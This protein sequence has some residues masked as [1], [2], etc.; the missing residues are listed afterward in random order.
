MRKIVILLYLSVSFYCSSQNKEILYNFT[1]LPQSLLTNP[2]A[3]VKYKWFLGVPLLSGISAN[4]GSKGINAYDL[5]A[6]N[7]V[8]FN[9]KIKEVI[10]KTNRNDYV[11]ANQQ[12]ELFS[13]GFRIGEPEDRSY[14]S[15]G[16]YQEFDSFIYI[17]TDIAILSV[18][19]NKDYVGKSFNLG[20]LSVKAELLS[21]LH[22]G[23]NKP[24][25]KKMTFGVRGKIYSSIF[26]ATST[27][28]SGYFHTV[29]GKNLIYDQSIRSNLTLNTSGAAKYLD[30]NYDGDFGSD[31]VEDVKQKALLGGNLGLGFDV[32]LTYYP[33]KNIQITASLVD[34]GYIKHT[35]E[36]KSYTLK[37]NYDFKGVITDFNSNGSIN[38]AYQDFKDAIP[39][40]TLYTAYATQ[41]PL[42]F[43]SSYQYSFEE[44]RQT[45]CNCDTDEDSWYRS[46]VGAQLFS[47]STPRAP[48]MALTAYYRRRFFNG[49]QMKATY[50]LDSYSYKNIG[51][52][53]YTKIGIANFYVLADN[54]LA[55]TD[56]A[57]ANALS[58]QIGFNI[59]SGGSNR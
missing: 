11:T 6:N 39:L 48:M 30:E 50:T 55:Y 16:M 19:G 42:K 40:D 32:G 37:G 27:H 3:D 2:G 56:L 21:V 29:Q 1:P 44:E 4:I 46:A 20:D 13:A 58:F 31:M 33:K 52:G 54:L 38:S 57:K 17:P 8:D 34:I 23:F 14:V 15:F 47:M 10:A 59:I 53:L 45:E 49:L 36:V 12:L 28:N 43:Y 35:Q 18:Y 9:T 22:I 26:N 7:G 41:R 25:N 24:I 5:F 51:L